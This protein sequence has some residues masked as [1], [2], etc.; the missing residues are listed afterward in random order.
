MS[1]S[2]SCKFLTIGASVAAAGAVFYYTWKT[3]GPSSTSS[4]N[5]QSSSTSRKSGNKLG[6]DKS[7]TSSLPYDEKYMIHCA[8]A[9]APG[10][11]LV[12]GGYLV[13]EPQFYGTVY[14]VSAYFH[15]MIGKLTEFQLKH[16]HFTP[17]AKR[18]LAF[19]EG[20]KK[21]H[22][23][24]LTTRRSS[25]PPTLLHFLVSLPQRT[26]HIVEYCVEINNRTSSP[27]GKSTM[28]F[29]SDCHL[30][31]LTPDAENNKFVEL[32]ILYCM[33]LVSSILPPDV[34]LQRSASPLLLR[35]FGDHQF[36][37]AT[38]STEQSILQNMSGKTGL[39]S[40][41][42]LVS[43]LVAAIFSHYGIISSSPLSIQLPGYYLKQQLSSSIVITPSPSPVSVTHNNETLSVPDTHFHPPQSPSSPA[44]PHE[45]E[46]SYI[47]VPTDRFHEVD[48]RSSVPRTPSPVLHLQEEV[49]AVLTVQDCRILAHNCAQ[50]IHCIAQGKVGSGF[51]V[52]SAY[53]GTHRYRRFSPNCIQA[54]L[55]SH[56]ATEENE[57][58]LNFQKSFPN[59]RM[60][61]AA[62]RDLL[63]QHVL[64]N[65]SVITSQLDDFSVNLNS[66]IQGS[67]FDSAITLIKDENS[68]NTP[69][70]QNTSSTIA[71]G[72]PSSSSSSSS[73]SSISPIHR[74]LSPTTSSIWNAASQGWDNEV[75]PLVL[76]PRIQLVLAD[77]QGGTETP[78][79]VKKVLHWR[80]VHHTESTKLWNL[81]SMANN[82]VNSLLGDLLNVSKWTQ[83][84]DTLDAA[85]ACP[86]SEWQN[87]KSTVPSATNQSQSKMIDARILQLLIDIQIAFQDVRKLIRQMGIASG[88]P[89]EPPFQTYLCDET[90]NIPGVVFAGVPGAGGDD[91]IFALTLVS[92]QGLDF[93]MNRISSFWESFTFK[94]NDSTLSRQIRLLPVHCIESGLKL[95]ETTVDLREWTMK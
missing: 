39:G 91:A 7:S 2:Q 4:F 6:S 67:Y 24:V 57:H 64:P 62:P 15:A 87:L 46:S 5:R 55:S 43:S 84:N 17:L 28:A 76:P 93:T 59:I 63:V 8:V 70:L 85:S 14:A 69:T 29:S 71:S 26:Q 31:C 13:L 42:A 75:T 40:S 20:T 66:R 94:S 50:L 81:L 72:A 18:E 80:S 61:V 52:S 56:S 36:Y 48:P 23:V 1:T 90:Q 78:S 83:Y 45:L 19:L 95:S 16:L 22:D 33:Q 32:S 11:V 21:K 65:C 34:F 10:K 77:V 35:L 49:T 47:I 88:T 86:A 92:S 9:A 44:H 73:S 30:Y 82:R 54:V 12:T 38:P 89:I 25:N 60:R 3:Y 51:D 53:F 79:M 41:A 74:Q 27:P 68:A 58:N 37:T